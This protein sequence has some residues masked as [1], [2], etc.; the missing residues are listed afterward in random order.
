[1]LFS[2][3]AMYESLILSRWFVEYFLVTEEYVFLVI[4][5]DG[6]FI[7]FNIDSETVIP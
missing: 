6:G 4:S 5:L 3:I 1:M 2:I 7:Y